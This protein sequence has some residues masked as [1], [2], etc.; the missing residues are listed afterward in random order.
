M[1]VNALIELIR[2]GLSLANSSIS[3]IVGA[4]ITTLF[5]RKNLNSTEFE[6]IKARKFSSVIDQLLEK[7]KMTY[8]E[9]Y[10]CN[11]FLSIAKKADE[12]LVESSDSDKSDNEKKYDFDWFIRFYDYASNISN[13]GMQ[14][15]WAAILAGE[16]NSPGSIS[17]SLLHSLSMMQ[18]EQAKFFCNI[19][20]FALW[21]IKYDVSHLL[22]F[23][24]TSREAYQS[25]GITPQLLKELERLGLIECDFV[26]EY[27]FLKKKVFRTG[28]KIITVYGDLDN[29][30]KIKAGNVNFTKDG[31]CLYSIIDRDFKS[32]RSDI[33]NFT[34]TKLKRRNC[35]IIINDQEAL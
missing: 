4:L 22:I 25:L 10:K 14:K 7:G 13:E 17:I 35:R 19:A 6:K 29:E 30:N 2:G 32:Y 1:D 24:S 3:A 16:V 28:N 18:Q 8:L 26:S 31:Q 21:D 15:L 11:N 20:R 12:N 9:Y 5:L 34:I 23:I 27:I 33:L